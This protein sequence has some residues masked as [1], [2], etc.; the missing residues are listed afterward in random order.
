MGTASRFFTG[1]H[2]ILERLDICF[3][4]RNTGGKPRREVLLQGM[5]GVGKSEIAFKFV[6]MFEDRLVHPLI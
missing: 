2:D 4:A 5:A 6:E 3:C 1:R